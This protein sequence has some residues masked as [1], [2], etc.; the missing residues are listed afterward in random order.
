MTY[1]LPKLER[2]H[3]EDEIQGGQL[4]LTDKKFTFQVQN[5]E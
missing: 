4:Q 1:K 5:W 2:S 3:E